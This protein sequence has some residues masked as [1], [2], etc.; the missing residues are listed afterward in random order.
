VALV[1]EAG[2]QT[3]RFNLE[4]KL[5]PLA[6]ELAPGP[7]A[8]ARA[9]VDVVQ[10]EDIASRTT[11]QSFDWRSLRAVQALAPRIALGCLSAEQRWFDTIGRGRAGASPWTAGLDIDQFG[12]D[13]AAL[14]A[15]AG[16]D[17][18]SPHAGD[19]DREAVRSAHRHGLRVVVW[20]VNDPAEMA[21]LIE[22]GVDGIITDYPDRL[23][24]V[25]AERSLTLPAPT[26][27]E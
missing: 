14:A 17:S 9:V 23:R 6:P 15:A 8:F 19:V 13:V 5:S 20:T 24:A 22:L 18:W 11:I 7:E 16:C 4:T 2:N 26:P 21:R 27:V 12:G 1:R 3:V 10:R 25:M